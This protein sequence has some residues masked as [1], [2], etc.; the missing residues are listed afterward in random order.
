MKDIEKENMLFNIMLFKYY[1]I[2]VLSM[3]WQPNIRKWF[4]PLY[5]LAFHPL[6]VHIIEGAMLASTTFVQS[7]DT[8]TCKEK[9][10]LHSVG[11]HVSYFSDQFLYSSIENTSNKS[12]ETFIFHNHLSSSCWHRTELSLSQFHAYGDQFAFLWTR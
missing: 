12:S 2:I 6:N 3:S 11:F 9:Y 8:A 4:W 7:L 10:T 5:L 1:I